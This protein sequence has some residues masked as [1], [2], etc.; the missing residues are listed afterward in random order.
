MNRI[1][2]KY[3]RKLRPIRNRIE[4]IWL[5]GSRARGDHRPD[6]DYDL[7]IVVDKRDRKILNAVYGAVVD[8]QLEEVV[9]ISAKVFTR[10]K[11]VELLKL[12]TP[13]MKAVLKEGIQVG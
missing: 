10:E 5:F 3:L 7:L 11:Y 6:S 1:L 9:D 2:S 13:F 12:R 8:L 4:S